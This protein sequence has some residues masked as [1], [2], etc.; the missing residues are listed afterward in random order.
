MRLCINR[1]FDDER[2]PKDATH[3]IVDES[4]TMIKE[5]AFNW[6]EILVSIIMGDNATSDNVKTVEE[7]AFYKFHDLRFI[8]LSKTLD[9]VGEEAFCH[10][11]SLEAFFSPST[12]KFVESEAFALC[13]LLRLIILPNTIDLGN[14][15]RN[16]INTTTVE[17]IVEMDGLELENDDR[18]N[19][20]LIH[21]MGYASFITAHLSTQRRSMTTSMNLEM[22]LRFRSTRFIV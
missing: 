20:W 13:R 8:R 16:I 1:G 18:V 10:C 21:H 4:V 15:D 6:C 3:V 17:Q 19:E 22:N 9:F 14:V 11:Q 7:F 12:V 5:Y 2:V